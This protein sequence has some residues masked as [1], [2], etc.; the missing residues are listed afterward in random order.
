MKEAWLTTLLL[1][2][3]LALLLP[4]PPTAA[5]AATEQ[6][7]DVEALLGP[8]DGSPLEGEELT[9]QTLEVGSLMRCPVCQGLS[10]A[11]SPS[12]SAVSMLSQ[13]RDLVAAGYS[14]AQILGY[15]ER[16]FGEFVLLQPKARG[17][18]LVVWL[19]PL[20]AVMLGLYLIR[21]RL[22]RPAPGPSASDSTELEEYLDRVRSEVDS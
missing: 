20:L 5:Q 18:N 13:V 21:R 4:V 16:S 1:S 12:S 6:S 9:T 19:A 22:R 8:P 2:A 15:F 3:L 7:I 14:E 10:I 17:F 11:D